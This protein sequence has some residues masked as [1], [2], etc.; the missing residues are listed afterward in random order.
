VDLLLTD[1]ELPG[2]SGPSLARELAAQRP[3]LKVLFLSGH[4][5]YALEAHGLVPETILEKPFPLSVL[6]ERVRLVLDG[7]QPPLPRGS[8]R[9]EK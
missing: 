1:V 4:A 8:E 3:G 6:A 7:D 5:H 2:G 9:N